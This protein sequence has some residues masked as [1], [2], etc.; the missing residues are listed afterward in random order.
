MPEVDSSAIRE[1]R[2]EARASRL[3][4]TFTSG[5]VYAYAP[6]RP[7]VYDAFLAAPSKGAFFNSEIRDRYRTTLIRGR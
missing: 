1:V 3:V 6:V 4:V 2:Y 7:D 5:K